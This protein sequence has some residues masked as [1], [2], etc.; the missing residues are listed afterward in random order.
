[1]EV[2]MSLASKK[3]LVV[4][5]MVSLAAM[6]FAHVA[7]ADEAP[8]P[9]HSTDQ[10]KSQRGVINLDTLIITSRVMT[11]QASIAVTKLEPKLT[12]TQLRVPLLAGI[13]SAIYGE[14]F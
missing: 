4:S 13:E 14:T 9:L 12:I 8:A 10:A 1:M 7:F 3:K 11:P 2:Q 6:A 5:A